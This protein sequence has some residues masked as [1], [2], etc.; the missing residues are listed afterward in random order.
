MT[1]TAITRHPIHLG[2]GATATIEPEFTGAMDWY[3]DYAARHADDG[4]EGRLVG[5]HSF[6][7]SWD[8]WEMHPNGSEIVLCIAGS[9]RL[10]QEFADGRSTSTQLDP[11]QYAINEPGTWHTADVEAEATVLFITAGAGTQHRPR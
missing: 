2:L 9:I 5:M 11:G 7:E 8:I 3:Q 6:S 1:G 10:H 4:R